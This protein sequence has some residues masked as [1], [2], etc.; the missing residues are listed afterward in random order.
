MTILLIE[1]DAVILKTNCRALELQGY[2][3]L[4]AKTLARG[5][6]L[7]KQNNPN[8]IVLDILLPDGNGLNYCEELRCNSNVPI[9]FL[10]AL[11]TNRDV[12]AG[13]KA[14]GNCY[15]AK[16][17]DMD[18]FLAQVEAM[19]RY[20][21]HSN[22]TLFFGELTLD[23]ISR[24]VNANGKDLLLRP[25]E[26]ALLE[27]LVKNKG[28]FLLQDELYHFVWGLNSSID[29]QTAA[30][31]EHICRLRRNLSGCTVVIES[32]R[33]KGYRIIKTCKR[34]NE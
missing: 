13:L 32:E 27:V 21:N 28:C 3:V 11:D 1:D 7:L 17:Y 12:V 30:V 2:H 5:H 26:F 14:G 24:R 31:K 19:L 33:G 25:K 18:V 23:M 4:C 20:G 8:M 9:L 15:L 16:P 29:T 6:A 34:D 22:S 10:S